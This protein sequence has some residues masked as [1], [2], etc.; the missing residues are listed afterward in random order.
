MK[1]LNA[2]IDVEVLSI[3]RRFMFS[4]MSKN[5]VMKGVSVKY[6]PIVCIF[7]SDLLNTNNINPRARET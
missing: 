6:N 3:I 2:E 7:P 5:P 4:T 1:G